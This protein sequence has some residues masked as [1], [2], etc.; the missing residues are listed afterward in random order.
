[1]NAFK[2]SKKFK[3]WIPAACLALLLGGC[4]GSKGG[5]DFPKDFN[6]RSDDEKIAYLMEAVEPDS[7][8]RFI[9]EASLGHI[10]DVSLRST[11]T[12]YLYAYEHYASQLPQQEKFIMEWDNHANTYSLE[13]KMRLVK[14]A[15]TED[16]MGIGLRLGLNYFEQLR[17]KKMTLKDVDAEVSAFRK[18]CG[19]DTTTY[20]Q[21]VKG[22][23]AALQ[24]DGG[25]QIDR[26]VY[27]K[28]I[29]MPE[30]L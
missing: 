16:P 25:R 7:V 24:T 14:A 29:N 22:F 11:N 27:A 6:S 19:S 26:A 18:A 20:V 12:A 9:I 15:G 13:E 4:S 23:K 10:P 28:Y 1:M 8:A 21:F 5:N 30:H 2:M 3:T 17:E